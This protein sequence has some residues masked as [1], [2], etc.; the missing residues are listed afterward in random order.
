MK[1][2]IS[3][4]SKKT[5][6]KKRCIG[7][8]IL[9]RSRSRVLSSVGCFTAAGYVYHSLVRRP[10]CRWFIR[11]KRQALLLRRP[12]RSLIH[13]LAKASQ[14]NSQNPSGETR[15]GGR[16]GRLGHPTG[17]LAFGEAPSPGPSRRREAPP[18]CPHWEAAPLPCARHFLWGTFL[19]Y[20]KGRKERVISSEPKNS[21]RSRRARRSAER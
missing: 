14:L 7:S 16:G 13:F 3:L 9:E 8:Y 12:I 11:K 5:D 18:A 19:L 20:L 1:G 4:S 15:V 2:D 21:C 10:W 17:T 6:P